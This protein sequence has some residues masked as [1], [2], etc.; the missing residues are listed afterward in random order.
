MPWVTKDHLDHVID[1]ARE[2]AEMLLTERKLLLVMS[3]VL[4]RKIDL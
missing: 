3:R 2:N 1:L 4:Q